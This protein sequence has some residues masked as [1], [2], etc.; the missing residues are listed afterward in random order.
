MISKNNEKS[1]LNNWEKEIMSVKNNWEKEILKLYE[2]WE[3]R[4]IFWVD[5]II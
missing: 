4:V 2:I 1:V 3:M 5:I